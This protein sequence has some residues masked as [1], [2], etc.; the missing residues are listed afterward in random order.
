[1]V[2]ILRARPIVLV[3]DD[4]QDTR[5]L[6]AHC[7]TLCGFA[8]EQA[9][10]GAE[11]IERAICVRPDVVLMD[12]AMPRMDGWTAT[13]R[14]RNEPRTAH[15]PIIILSAHASDRDRERLLAAGASEF[16]SKPCD[17]DVLASRLRHYS[18]DAQRLSYP[19]TGQ[20]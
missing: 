17:L 9:R 1:M 19:P 4:D 13:V 10:D 11:G 8:V 6:Y 16:L 7:L 3:V 12:L 18:A 2:R 20:W 15:L 5:D 14:L